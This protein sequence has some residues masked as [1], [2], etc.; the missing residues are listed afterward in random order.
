LKS[1]AYERQA[2]AGTGE[3]LYRDEVAV[4]RWVLALAASLPVGSSAVVS[5]ALLASGIAALPALAPV[6]GAAALAAI[7]TGLMVVYAVGRVAVSEGELHVRIGPNGPRV[8]IDAIESFD[9]GPSG[10]RRQGLGYRKL[11]DGAALYSLMGENARAVRI[12]RRD[13]PPLVL[14]VRD[15]DG[16]VAALREAKARRVTQARVE[17]DDRGERDEVTAST[18]ESRAKKRV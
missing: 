13:Q 17:V 10:I 11:A 18:T 2:M 8:P 6:L 15:P 3:V 1:D 7:A 12:V 4:P 14:V 9:I 16:L 5:A